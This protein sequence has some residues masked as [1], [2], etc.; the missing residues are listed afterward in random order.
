MSICSSCSINCQ[1]P[2]DEYP[3]P[4]NIAVNKNGIIMCIPCADVIDSFGDDSRPVLKPVLQTKPIPQQMTEKKSSA[5]TYINC[6]NCQIKFTG[7]K[8]QCGYKN[9]LYRT[10]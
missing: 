7:A 10:K 8:C 4:R 6:K 5:I 1:L 2:T 9:P 3:N